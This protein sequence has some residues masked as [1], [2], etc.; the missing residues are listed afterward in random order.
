[1]P[2][3]DSLIEIYEDGVHRIKENDVAL[4]Y[5]FEKN[6]KA[7]EVF[8]PDI[9]SELVKYTPDKKSVFLTENGG[10]NIIDINSHEVLFD[11][12]PLECSL[13]KVRKYLSNPSK[14]YLNFSNKKR[15][16]NTLHEDLL[17]KVGSISGLMENEVKQVELPE[18]IPSFLMLGIDFG[19]SLYY[20][21]EIYEFGNLFVYEKDFDY[22]Y[23][24]LYAI[25]WNRVLE[26][27]SETKCDLHFCLGMEEKEFVDFYYSF[28]YIN[29]FFL[30]A[31]TYIY[32]SRESSY[33]KAF[34]YLKRDYNKQTFGWGFFDDAMQGIA[35]SF[36]S[37]KEKLIFGG[38]EG[39]NN[40]YSDFPVAIIA[41][42]PS[43]DKDI[44]F[45]IKN[46]DR[47]IV[48]SC[49]TTINT[50]YKYGVKPDFHVDV[51]RRKQ[52]AEK[53]S[54]L[55]DSYLNGIYAL[56]VDII[57]PD[58]YEY[59]ENVGAALKPGEPASTLII[60]SFPDKKLQRLDYSG[61]MV[62]NTA[63]AYF[64]TMGFKEVL[65][66]GVDCGFERPDQHHS[67]LSGYFKDGVD[68]GLVEYDDEELPEVKGNKTD[69]VYTNYLYD[70]SRL[71][72]EDSISKALHSNF[73]NFSN[74]A[75]IEGATPKD[76][77]DFKLDK[78]FTISKNDISEF[79]FDSFFYKLN[80]SDEN[81]YLDFCS[82][83]KEICD[84][85]K[86]GWANEKSR[87]GIVEKAALFQRYLVDK[88]RSGA[89][90]AYEVIIGTFTYFYNI[91]VDFIYRYE[92]SDLLYERSLDMYNE[93]CAFIEKAEES[94]KN[95]NCFLDEG[96]GWLMDKYS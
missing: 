42:G 5:R 1:M 83:F 43:L 58:F 90:V 38:W 93:F 33:L 19:Y 35:H 6:L 63:L 23:Y 53:L 47:L 84:V 51:E 72:L 7:F 81:F 80:F 79:V 76:T 86:S 87:R 10:L 15:E 24:S 77:N 37:R 13:E 89:K 71:A 52:T 48:V 9:Y 82:D 34:S 95:L 56:S 66:F 59:F 94:I 60:D 28:R 44:D 57:H 65:F 50:L 85:L 78:E 92:W 12:C 41:N 55:P 96:D 22:F 14:S 30:S 88:Y 4:S 39:V 20:L 32:A 70:A 26:K 68:V 16:F 45:I 31:N 40:I 49:G 11:G 46:K 27:L 62:S 3:V 61:P 69:K 25:E 17:K 75:Y 73:Y 54:L 29:G 18:Y 64:N 74:G 91:L 21:S 67:R 8:F 2:T 36:L